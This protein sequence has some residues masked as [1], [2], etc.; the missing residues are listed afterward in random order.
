MISHLQK[1]PDFTDQ[2]IHAIKLN[3]IKLLITGY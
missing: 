2:V 3:Y 1:T